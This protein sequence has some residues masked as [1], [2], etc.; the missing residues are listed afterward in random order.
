[1][2]L[3]EIKIASQKILDDMYEFINLKNRDSIIFKLITGVV[4]LKKSRGFSR[5]N[6]STDISNDE[7]YRISGISK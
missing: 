6:S 3:N 1:M 5:E 7:N 2:S 4:G